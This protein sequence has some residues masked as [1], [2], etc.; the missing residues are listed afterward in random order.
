MRHHFCSAECLDHGY[1]N[2]F[3]LIDIES[4]AGLMEKLVKQKQAL[5]ADWGTV[6]PTIP[7]ELILKAIA[8]EILASNPKLRTYHSRPGS[9]A[10]AERT[11]KHKLKVLEAFKPTKRRLEIDQQCAHLA[12]YASRL[13]LDYSPFNIDQRLVLD[14]A[15][16]L[17]DVHQTIVLNVPEDKTLDNYIANGSSTP[18]LSDTSASNGSNSSTVSATNG[19]QISPNGSNDDAAQIK[20]GL[21]KED[22]DLLNLSDKEI[23]VAGAGDLH[24]VWQPV[25]S[26]VYTGQAHINHS[27][28]PNVHYSTIDN[29]IHQLDVVAARPIA[30]GEQICA[31]YLD[32]SL[33]TLP[34][35]TRKAHLLNNFG[36]DCECPACVASKSD[37]KSA[38][39]KSKHVRR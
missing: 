14:T 1:M 20:I 31:S 17:W 27:C 36:F 19:N 12:E 29:H 23:K 35:A 10:F 25:A 21:S 2:Y 6:L 26:A 16:R 38:P 28:V 8:M 5:D 37:V 13:L 22:R 3:Q 9:R 39:A 34:A 15:K 30:A 11:S 7:P 4:R 18:S 33:L 32:T 24:L